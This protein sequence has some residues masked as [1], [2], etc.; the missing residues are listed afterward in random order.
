VLFVLTEKQ[1]K[2]IRT[3]Q[4]DRLLTKIDWAF[5]NSPYNI[6]DLL[7]QAIEAESWS[8]NY[9]K[10]IFTDL[11]PVEDQVYHSQP[12]GLYLIIKD[13]RLIDYASA[14]GLDTWGKELHELNPGMVNGWLG[15]GFLLH[16]D[17]EKAI[18]YV[19]LQANAWASLP[20][21][22]N[23]EHVPAYTRKDSTVD[24]F[25]ILAA[26]VKM[27]VSLADFQLRIGTKRAAN[28]TRDGE[29]T[30]HEY[31]GKQFYFMEGVLQSVR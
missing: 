18:N 9:M 22:L 12:N 2:K 4:V 27:S 14:D 11:D 16:G 13:G 20:D 10:K 24:F 3:S 26:E 5:E 25:M 7:D 30:V 31:D 1:V 19:N 8:V 21:S 6:E 28:S 17:H 29:A 23:N 15:E